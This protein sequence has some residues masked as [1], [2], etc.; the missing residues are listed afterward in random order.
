MLRLIA[1]FLVLLVPSLYQNSYANHDGHGPDCN[2]MPP[3]FSISY[4]DE[5][6]DGNITQKE[7]L[8]G[9]SEHTAKMFEHLDANH[10]GKLDK[11]EQDEIE[12]VYTLMH[13]EKMSQKKT[14]SI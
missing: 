7:Y 3:N 11:A 5:N 9:D 2:G 12:K 6:K 10:D 1:V 14:K 13:Q 8:A 4:L